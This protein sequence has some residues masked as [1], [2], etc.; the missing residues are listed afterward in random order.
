MLALEFAASTIRHYTSDSYN[1]TNRCYLVHQFQ[2]LVL[3]V[4]ASILLDSSGKARHYLFETVKDISRGTSS[5]PEDVQ[6]SILKSLPDCST[7]EILVTIKDIPVR[8]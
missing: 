8:P 1:I 3:P 7:N 2:F 4:T 5:L 6:C